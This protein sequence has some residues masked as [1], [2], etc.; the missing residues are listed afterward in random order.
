MVG[1]TLKYM[2]KVARGMCVSSWR[3]PRG[4]CRHAWPDKRN[5]CAQVGMPEVDEVVGATLNYKLKVARGNVRKFLAS[6]TEGVQLGAYADVVDK[7]LAAVDEIE[8]KTGAPLDAAN[9]K[10]WKT[11]AKRVE[12]SFGVDKTPL[13]VCGNHSEKSHMHVHSQSHTSSTCPVARRGT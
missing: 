4:A 1:A 13:S 3:A 2:L 5:E 7:I 8:E 9:E 11:L 12:V 10:G 6:A